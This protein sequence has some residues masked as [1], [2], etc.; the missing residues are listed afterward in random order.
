MNNY[1]AVLGIFFPS[2]VM[3]QST[4][5]TG[6]DSRLKK[7]KNVMNLISILTSIKCKLLILHVYHLSGI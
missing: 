7:K 2:Y 6:N 1:L 3:A 4:K 5:Y